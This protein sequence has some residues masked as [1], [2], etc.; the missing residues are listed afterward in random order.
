M[1]SRT[2]SPWIHTLG[3]SMVLIGLP[4]L[5]CKK[6]KPSPASC[7]PRDTITYS[8]YVA[9]VMRQYCISCHSGSSPSGG[10]AL[11][12]YA[13]VKASA[14]SGKWYSSMSQGRMPPSGKLDECTL[15]Y[16][17]KWIDTGYQP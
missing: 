16:L 5:S 17:K 1:I 15:S 11:E 4:L 7:P 13:Q 12:T 9:G 2:K 6:E 10:V 8:N 14:Q 3:M